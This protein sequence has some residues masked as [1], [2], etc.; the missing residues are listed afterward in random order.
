MRSRRPAYALEE[1]TERLIKKHWPFVEYIAKK[2]LMKEKLTVE[3][4]NDLWKNFQ[5]KK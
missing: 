3:V 5:L 4:I 2:L 1:E